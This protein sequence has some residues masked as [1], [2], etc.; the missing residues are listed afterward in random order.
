MIREELS[1]EIRAGLN[2][3]HTLPMDAE[4]TT[5]QAIR[6]MTLYEDIRCLK[7]RTAPLRYQIADGDLY[8]W[9]HDVRWL[10][11]EYKDK[12]WEKV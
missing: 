12:R 7:H 5:E 6:D 9:D 3:L 10:E 1:R 4:I 2:K 8:Y 11:K